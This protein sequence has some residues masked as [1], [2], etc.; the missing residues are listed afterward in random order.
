MS[1]NKISISSALIVGLGASASL[2]SVQPTQAQSTY[3]ECM[4]EA[5]ADFQQCLIERGVEDSMYGIITGDPSVLIDTV[6]G[7]AACG[8]GYAYD[9]W[10]CQNKPYP[11]Q[12][13]NQNPQYPYQYDSNGDGIPDS[14]YW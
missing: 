4:A 12:S 9:W 5:G 7:S 11:G 6:S 13:P 1:L 10:E 2:I 8:A 3:E 14:S